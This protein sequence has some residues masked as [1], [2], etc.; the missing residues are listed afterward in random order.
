M[1]DVTHHRIFKVC[2]VARFMFSY[3]CNCFFIASCN[4]NEISRIVD[5]MENV[6]YEGESVC[7][8]DD[9]K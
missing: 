7:V 4:E 8:T 3:V 1:A 6:F 9:R 2:T 5:S